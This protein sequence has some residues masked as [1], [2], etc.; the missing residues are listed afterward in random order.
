MKYSTIRWKNSPIWAHYEDSQIQFGDTTGVLDIAI[1][2]NIQVH[3]PETNPIHAASSRWFPDHWCKSKNAYKIPSV[4]LDL[5]VLNGVCS[6]FRQVHYCKDCR[7]CVCYNRILVTVQHTSPSHNAKC[8]HCSATSRNILLTFIVPTPQTRSMNLDH[9]GSQKI[10]FHNFGQ[11]SV[12]DSSDHRA[13]YCKFTSLEVI[14]L[15]H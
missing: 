14:K 2:T 6:G 5:P 8:N 12:H 9:Y 11:A 13:S 3:L 10:L 1:K 15:E 7:M 4:L